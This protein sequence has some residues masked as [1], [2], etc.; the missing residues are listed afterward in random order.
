MAC[1]WMKKHLVAFLFLTQASKHCRL[2]SCYFSK[3]VPKRRR[4]KSFTRGSVSGRSLRGGSL[5]IKPE[6]PA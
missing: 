6:M 3:Y 2:K 5:K 4:L 1:V